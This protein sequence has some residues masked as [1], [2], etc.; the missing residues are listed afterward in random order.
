M[1]GGEA[2]REDDCNQERSLSAEGT[3]GRQESPQSVTVWPSPTL[4]LLSDA[5]GRVCLFPALILARHPW[6]ARANQVHQSPPSRWTMPESF[7]EN[8]TLN[9][10]PASSPLPVPFSVLSCLLLS[11]LWL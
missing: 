3:P 6:A 7:Q 9:S 10:S 11:C 5:W 1:T 8:N 4:L 2:V